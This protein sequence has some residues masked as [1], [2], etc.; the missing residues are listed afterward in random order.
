VSRAPAL[1]PGGPAAAPEPPAGWSAL[2]EEIAACRRCD[3][4]KTRRQVVI[5]RGAPRPKVLFIGEAPGAAEDLAG[6][7]FVGRSGRRLDA[8]AH[9]VGLAAD[10]WGVLNLIKCR[11][12]ENRF[13][14]A[15]SEACRPFLLR[16]LDLLDPSV[17]VTLGR[18]ALAALDPAAPPITQAAGVP[19]SW[20]GRPMFPLLH[21]AAALHAPRLRERWARDLVAL[22]AFLAPLAQNL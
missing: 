11:P 3:L 20:N 17:L 16:Q 15:S 18:H 10:A 2:S 21:P 9:E 1:A 4:Y 19:R 22:G 12:P 6:L 5:Y 14:P 7:P 8:A 13:P